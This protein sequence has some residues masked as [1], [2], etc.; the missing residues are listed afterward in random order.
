M[1]RLDEDSSDDDDDGDGD[2]EDD[3]WGPDD[4][5]PVIPVRGGVSVNT[6][7]GGDDGGQS[8]PRHTNRENRGVP[9]LRFIEMYMAAVADGEV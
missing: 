8:E 7:A 5:A 1:P 9:P 3:G 6:A 2:G 4:D